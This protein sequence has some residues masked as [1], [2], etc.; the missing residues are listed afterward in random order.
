[1]KLLGEAAQTGMIQDA[2]DT[3]SAIATEGAADIL[4]SMSRRPTECNA[5][6]IRD[7]RSNRSFMHN[8]DKIASSPEG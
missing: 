2:S 4:D 5:V 7:P 8:P 6:D 3:F 1:M